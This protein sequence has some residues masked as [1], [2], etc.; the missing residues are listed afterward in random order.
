MRR[1]GSLNTEENVLFYFKQL[2]NGFKDLYKHNIIHRDIKPD[3]IL[4]HNNT[5]K[6]GDFGLSQQLF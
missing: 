4:A 5:L 3:N 6:I 1:D 2:I